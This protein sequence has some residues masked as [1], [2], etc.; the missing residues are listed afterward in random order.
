MTEEVVDWAEGRG[1]SRRASVGWVEGVYAG[2][3]VAEGVVD[4]W[5]GVGG[6]CVYCEVGCWR[7]RSRL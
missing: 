4:E 2:R 6:R 7:A 1:T 3:L 5:M